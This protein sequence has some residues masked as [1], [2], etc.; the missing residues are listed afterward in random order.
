[1]EHRDFEIVYHD[2]TEVL[3]ADRRHLTPAQSMK[4]VQ[5][6]AILEDAKIRY[7]VRGI[8][9][10]HMALA[11]LFFA[12]HIYYFTKGL[13]YD[14]FAGLHGDYNLNYAFGI[15]NNKCMMQ[16]YRPEIFYRQ[17]TRF[18]YDLEKEAIK[19]EKQGE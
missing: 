8:S 17:A 13:I 7:R 15:S 2:N 9:S 19:L 1:M 10:A 12:P 11:G 4:I 3:L 5:Q 6:Y 16:L 14:G 18:F